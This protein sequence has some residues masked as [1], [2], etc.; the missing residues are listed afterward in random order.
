M[1]KEFSRIEKRDVFMIKR[2]LNIT[3]KIE[4]ITFLLRTYFYNK[5]VNSKTE[6]GCF[7]FLFSFFE[8]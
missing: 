2:Q 6:I 4:V 1:I 8:V 7:I 3:R 5:R